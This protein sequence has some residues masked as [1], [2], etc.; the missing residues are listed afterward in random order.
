VA[1]ELESVV[2]R[3]AAGEVKAFVEITR[4][5]EHLAFGSALAIVH[6]FHHAEDVAQ[7]AFLVAWSALPSL[8]DPAAFPGWLRS[9]VRRQAFRQLRRKSV[10]TVPLAEAEDVRSEEPAGDHL[11][12]Q[13]P[14]GGGS[15]G[16]DCRTAEPPASPRHYFSC[17]SARIETSPPFSRVFLR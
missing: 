10:H 11:L 17:T 12:E 7:E 5:F 9:I 14:T 13:T 1:L 8:A 15:V 4:R 2:R 16:G 3:A 6:D